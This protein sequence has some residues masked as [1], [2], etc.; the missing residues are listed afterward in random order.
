MPNKRTRAG[1]VVKPG[2]VKPGVVKP[3]T[4]IVRKPDIA[5]YYA[6]STGVLGTTYDFSLVFGRIGVAPSGEPIVEQ[7][8][9]VTMSYQHALAV[10]ALLKENLDAY[11]ARVGN[12]PNHSTT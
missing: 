11:A 4:K 12:A 6:N 2:V 8:A 3:A 10:Q 7:F 9:L 5:M 1:A